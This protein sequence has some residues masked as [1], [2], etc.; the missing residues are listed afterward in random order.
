MSSH[1]Y[2]QSLNSANDFQSEI[3]FHAKS[4]TEICEFNENVIGYKTIFGIH[5]AIYYILADTIFF[6][7]IFLTNK[8]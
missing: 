7:S 8:H 5:I 4:L 1:K 2:R 3:R 6:F